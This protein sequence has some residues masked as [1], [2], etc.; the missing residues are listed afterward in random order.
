LLGVC[1]LLNIPFVVIVQAHLLKDKGAVR[2]RRVLPDDLDI[3][4]HT[5]SGGGN[6]QFVPL[7]MLASTIREMSA[8]SNAG[9]EERNTGEAEQ[10]TGNLSSRDLN[11]IRVAAE[12]ECIYI[13]QENFFTDDA[14]EQDG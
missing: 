3:G 11:S 2:L 13:D 7:E 12:V 8:E 9:A 5:G 1:S 10:D 4:W 14:K 6:E